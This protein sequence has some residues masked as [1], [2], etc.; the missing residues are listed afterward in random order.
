MDGERLQ[1]QAYFLRTGGDELGD[2]VQ[3]GVRHA[4]VDVI[5]RGQ[6]IPGTSRT[7]VQRH[8][9]VQGLA[10]Q[11]DNV[12]VTPLHP[13]L[14][15]RPGGVL[16]VHLI[17]GRLDQLALA[18]QGQQHQPQGQLDRGIRGDCLQLMKGQP[19]FGWAQRPV[20]RHESGDGR[21]FNVVSRILDLLA[22]Q[23]RERI[24][25][26]HDVA[27]MDRSCR[28][29]T[30]LYLGTQGSQIVRGDF[31]QQPVFEDRQDVAVDDAFTH[32]ARAVG[33]ARTGQPLRQRFTEILG[34]VQAPFSAL[35][36]K[37]GRLAQGDH[38][39]GIEQLLA[40]HGQGN[41]SWPIA[42]D[43][44]RFSAS[45]ETVV[46]AKGDGTGR[47]YRHVHP[48]AVGSLVQLG[49]GLEIAQFGISKHR[50][51]YSCS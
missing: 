50:G 19:N 23:D 8:E 42:P 48:I 30:S 38:A 1:R 12:R 14:G 17:P 20:L 44:Q 43:G 46:V 3:G 37:R 15:D 35:L 9:Y 21:R 49:L 45:I 4:A 36:L 5:A 2:A 11:V 25:L 6:H 41:A 39:L 31:G 33:H 24:D 13:L 40:S 47:R 32:R 7:G 28:R 34:S 29:P 26:F 27:N 10:R 22:M 16:E 51:F 18:Y